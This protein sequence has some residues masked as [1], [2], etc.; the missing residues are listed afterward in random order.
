MDE[1]FYGGV[2]L[3][4]G[5]SQQSYDCLQLTGIVAHLQPKRVDLKFC[6]YFRKPGAHV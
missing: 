6:C 4:I 5:I 3:M 2:G 1:T